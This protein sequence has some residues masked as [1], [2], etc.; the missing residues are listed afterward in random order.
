MAR[1][2]QMKRVQVQLF[3]STGTRS[4]EI[5]PKGF[6][7]RHIQRR[8]VVET[9]PIT[10]TPDIPKPEPLQV[11]TPEAPKQPLKELLQEVDA[12]MT[13]KPTLSEGQAMILGALKKA[14]YAIDLARIER[15]TGLNSLYILLECRELATLGF[16]ESVSTLTCRKFRASRKGTEVSA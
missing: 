6:T 14:G 3:G 7:T 9:E 4:T 12:A 8:S 16:I 5:Q 13:P 11:S 2:S 15:A 1:K 10:I